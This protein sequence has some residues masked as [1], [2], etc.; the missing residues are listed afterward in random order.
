MKTFRRDDVDGAELRDEEMLLA[1]LSARFEG[2]NTQAPHSV[3]GI[4]RPAEYLADVTL[5]TSR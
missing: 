3:L 1:Q 4:R 5:S 2:Y